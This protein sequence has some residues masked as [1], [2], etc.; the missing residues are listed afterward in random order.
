MLRHVNHAIITT[1]IL[2][3]EHA[4]RPGDGWRQRVP[5]PTREAA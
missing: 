5:R 1:I 2:L 3:L 4:R